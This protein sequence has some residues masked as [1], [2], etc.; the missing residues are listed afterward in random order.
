MSVCVH[1]SKNL[2]WI[3]MKLSKLIDLARC[4]VR[5]TDQWLTNDTC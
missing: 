4:H 2:T 5:V 3:S 1:N